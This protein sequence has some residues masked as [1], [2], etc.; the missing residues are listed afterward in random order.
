MVDR[1]LVEGFFNGAKAISM[2]AYPEER[3]SK[4]ISLYADGSVTV[5]E[6]YVASMGSIFD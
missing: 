6:L 2:R 1:S 3:D 4:A 5:K